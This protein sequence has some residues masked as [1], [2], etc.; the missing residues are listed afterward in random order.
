MEGDNAPE[1]GRPAPYFMPYN[2]RGHASGFRG[3]HWCWVREAGESE[4]GKPR[5][6]DERTMIDTSV[7]YTVG[8]GEV[9]G[10]INSITA[11]G[12][13]VSA[14]SCLCFEGSGKGKLLDIPKIPYRR[15]KRTIDSLS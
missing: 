3:I 6:L 13:V 11:K 12:S 2:P 8:T 14:E 9:A 7:F 1:E 5:G 4:L 10:S 15:C